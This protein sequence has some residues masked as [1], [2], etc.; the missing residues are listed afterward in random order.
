MRRAGAR[1]HSGCEAS[2]LWRHLLSGRRQLFGLPH[3]GELRVEIG[4]LV[5]S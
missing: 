1:W 5:K 4:A 2:A 3:C